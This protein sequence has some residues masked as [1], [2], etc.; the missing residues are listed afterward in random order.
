VSYL[1]QIK[2]QNTNTKSTIHLQAIVPSHLNNMRL[3]K[4]V[5]ELFSD[6]S[7]SRLQSWIREGKVLVDG[8][9][10]RPRDLVYT[11]EKITVDAI[12]LPQEIWKAQEITLDIIYEDEALLVINKPVGLVVHPAAGNPDN[13]LVNALLNHCSA[14]NQIPRAG[15]VHRLDKDTSGLLVV[16]KTLA[17][18]THLVKQLQARTVEREYDAIVD[19]HLISGATV[20]EPIG[21]HP[22]Q[23]TKMSV[24][25]MG[26]TAITHYRVVERFGAYTRIKVKLETGRT[27]QIRVHMAHTH[28]PILGDK[29]YNHRLKLPK[30]ASEN[31]ISA[32]RNFKHQALHAARLGL[33]HPITQQY[34][35]WEVNVPNDMKELIDI[36]RK[37]KMNHE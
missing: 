10:K 3:D 9:I 4:V 35:E 2:M 17:A 16:A 6:Y 27:H 25:T 23:R 36:L 1:E 33:I 29:T 13:T 24:N 28:H 12:L 34:M 21:R 19:G 7:R 30:N 26:K 5:A 20:D 15:I 8:K 32:L 22:T 18:H 37:E 31:L 11:N 14:L